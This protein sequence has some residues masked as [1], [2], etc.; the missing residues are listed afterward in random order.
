MDNLIKYAWELLARTHRYQ[1]GGTNPI[2]GFDCSG[3][4][5]ELLLACGEIS[6][7]T[8]KQSAQMLYNRFESEGNRSYGAGALAFYGT[9]AS[10]IDHVGFCLDT[11]SMLE[12]GGG[13]ASTV[14]DADAIAHNAFVKMRPIKYRKDF[15]CVIKPKYVGIG[16]M[17]P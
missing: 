12:A 10:K 5:Q 6:F 4:V 13:T 14:S 3:F 1:F 2:I 9:N 17:N 8:P 15:L 16:M 7:G 11:Y